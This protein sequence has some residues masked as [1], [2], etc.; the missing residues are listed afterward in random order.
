MRET[1]VE[2]SSVQLISDVLAP[3]IV[4]QFI[5]VALITQENI[6]TVKFPRPESESFF[7]ISNLREPTKKHVL[8]CSLTKSP[9]YAGPFLKFCYILL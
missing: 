9:L 6:F 4:R 1:S 2:T 7:T 3:R 5:V 8:F